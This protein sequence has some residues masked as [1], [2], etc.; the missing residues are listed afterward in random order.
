MPFSPAFAERLRTKERR[1]L[2][3]WLV[4]VEPIIYLSQLLLGLG[5]A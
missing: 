2:H 3:N 1:W 4:F 5:V